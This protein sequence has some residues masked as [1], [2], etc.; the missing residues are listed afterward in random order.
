MLLFR[1][2]TGYRVIIRWYDTGWQNSDGEMGEKRIE[3]NG[4]LG[5]GESRAFSSLAL[6]A[7]PSPSSFV[8]NIDCVSASSLIH[9]QTHLLM[10]QANKIYVVVAGWEWTANIQFFAFFSSGRCLTICWWNWLQSKQRN[11]QL[12]LASQGA[13]R[14]RRGSLY[15]VQ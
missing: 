10:T 4:D 11:W 14:I 1:V 9:W 12:K 15:W 5:M 8:P 2:L 7:L 6:I 3:K 13:N